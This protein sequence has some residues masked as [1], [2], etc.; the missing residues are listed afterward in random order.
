M[1]DMTPQSGGPWGFAGDR[2]ARLVVV[3]AETRPRGCW[4]GIGRA[5]Q[6][7]LSPAVSVQEDMQ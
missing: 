4:S 7:V 3:S 5:V 1:T 2:N 6:R